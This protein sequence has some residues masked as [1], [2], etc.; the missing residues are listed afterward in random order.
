MEIQSKDLKNA[1]VPFSD[2][3]IGSMFLHNGHIYGRSEQFGRSLGSTC[4]SIP[5]DALCQIVKIESITVV[6][7]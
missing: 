5:S 1:P 2:I 3:P 7:V 6:D 4:V